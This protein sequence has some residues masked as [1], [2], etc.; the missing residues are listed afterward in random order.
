MVNP[1][2]RSK[3]KYMKK[4]SRGEIVIYQT[5]DGKTVLD[6]NLLEETLWLDQ[7]Q[8]SILFDRDR[9]VITKHLHN[10]FKSGELDKKS[11]VQKMHIAGSDKP[12]AYY[13]LDVIIS[14]GY[15]V[16]SKRGIQ[17]R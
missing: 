14:L 6:V 5:K 10:I 16:N 9:S 13:N 17:F 11:N 4:E 15:R 8:M 3:D 12:V 2:S 1:D 7:G